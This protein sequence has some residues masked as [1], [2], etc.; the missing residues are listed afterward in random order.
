MYLQSTVLE[1]LCRTLPTTYSRPGVE[2]EGQSS[3]TR[4]HC[5]VSARIDF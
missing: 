4:L 1:M 2:V 3:M 5:P